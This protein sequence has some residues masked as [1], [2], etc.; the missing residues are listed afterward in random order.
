MLLDGDVDASEIGDDDASDTGDE[1]MSTLMPVVFLAC[2]VSMLL[3]FLLVLVFW[4][5]V[6]NAKSPVGDQIGRA[7]V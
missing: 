2:G 5:L 3:S 1:G 7:H 6:G 4:F